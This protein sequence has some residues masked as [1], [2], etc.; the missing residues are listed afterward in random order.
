MVSFVYYFLILLYPI[1]LITSFLYCSICLFLTFTLFLIILF[2]SRLFLF[3]FCLFV[4][5]VVCLLY[6]ILAGSGGSVL[7]AKRRSNEF[8][9]SS[10]YQPL[11]ERML[12]L[13]FLY[14]LLSLSL[15]LS[16][17]LTQISCQ[18][19]HTYST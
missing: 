16:L 18:E 10:E 3:F 12:T 19:Y 9:K 15:S 5:L 7:T 4:C 8:R 14:T 1:M 11:V 2:A 6:I 13:H 17:T